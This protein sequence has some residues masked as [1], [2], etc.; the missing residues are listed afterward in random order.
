MLYTILKYL[1]K[2]EL[3]IFF[4]KIRINKPAYLKSRGPLLVAI[5]HPNSFLDA[6]VLDIFFREP[7]W[8]LA[9]GDAFKGNRIKKILHGLRIMP[10]YRSSEGVENLSANYK[11]FEACIAIFRENGLVQIFSEGKCINEW[12]LRPLRK[13]SARLAIK[14]WEEGIPLQV[15][16]AGINYS[17]FTKFGKNVVLNFGSPFGKEVVDLNAADGIRNQQFNQQLQQQMEEL[18][19]EIPPTDGERRNSLL[20]NSVP[21]WKWVLL[22]L[23]AFLGLLINAPLYLAIRNFVRKRTRRTVHYDSVMMGLLLITY[24]LYLLVLTLAA[25]FITDNGY[26]WGLF[27]FIPFTAWSCVQLKSWK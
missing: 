18:V 20:G 10:V 23:P 25:Y 26:A 1:V 13:G 21:A 4:R 9:R 27:L 15:L 24:P 19:F 5:N 3:L 16:P 2:L 12:H 7:L 11:T 22:G 17:S 14:A 6:I 8:S